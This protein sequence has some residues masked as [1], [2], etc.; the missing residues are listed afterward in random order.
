MTQRSRNS[1]TSVSTTASRVS[2]VGLMFGT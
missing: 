1:R 2:T